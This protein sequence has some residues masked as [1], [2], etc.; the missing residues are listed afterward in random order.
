[1]LEVWVTPQ[2][3]KSVIGLE[4]DLDEAEL[5]K[6]VPPVACANADVYEITDTRT[7]EIAYSIDYNAELIRID[8]EDDEDD[9]YE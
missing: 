5:L 2:F 4:E 9:I 8:L 1:M 6:L 7:G 3:L